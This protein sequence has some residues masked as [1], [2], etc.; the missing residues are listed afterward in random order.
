M[1]CE[2]EISRNRVVKKTASSLAGLMLQWEINEQ[3]VHNVISDSPKCSEGEEEERRTVGEQG[4]L[5]LVGSVRKSH[6]KARDT[7][8]LK[9][10]GK[11]LR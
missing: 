1:R 2:S 11:S 3:Y 5:F 4:K 10:E 6:S 9:C 7:N 8:Q